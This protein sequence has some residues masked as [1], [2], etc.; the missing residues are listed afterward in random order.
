M[1]A[2]GSRRIPRYVPSLYLPGSFGRYRQYP[3]VT[4]TEIPGAGLSVGK[5]IW[6]EQVLDLDNRYGSAPFNYDRVPL[7]GLGQVL[8]LNTR[9]TQ[10]FCAGALTALGLISLNSAWASGGRRWWPGR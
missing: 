5:L 6:G 10:V 2:T 8:G 3:R 9:D 7:L 1:M 4:R